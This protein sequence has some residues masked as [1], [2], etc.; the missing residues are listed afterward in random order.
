MELLGKV[1]FALLCLEVVAT[2]V[3]AIGVWWDR[4]KRDKTERRGEL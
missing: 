1:C 3:L 4:R 2:T